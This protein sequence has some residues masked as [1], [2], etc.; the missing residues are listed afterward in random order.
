MRYKN[1]KQ[2]IWIHRCEQSRSKWRSS[3]SVNARSFYFSS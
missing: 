1:R 2:K 3:T